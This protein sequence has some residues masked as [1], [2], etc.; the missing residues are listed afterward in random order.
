MEFRLSTEQELWKNTV[1]E[2]AQAEL[3]PIARKIDEEWERIPKEVIKKMA[4]LGIFG[5]TSP[6]GVWR[7]RRARRDVAVCHDYY[8]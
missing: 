8:S 3:E 6:G 4:D 5:V 2:F 7:Q 1:R